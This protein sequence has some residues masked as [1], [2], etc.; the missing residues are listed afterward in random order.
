[1]K[2]SGRGALCQCLAVQI[3]SKCITARTVRAACMPA[4]LFSP[5][6]T[7]IVDGLAR[8]C[9][10]HNPLILLLAAIYMRPLICLRPLV[11]PKPESDEELFSARR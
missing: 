11:S 2:G 8:L 6:R 7:K 10:W 3:C 4:P 9:P 1:M 5:V